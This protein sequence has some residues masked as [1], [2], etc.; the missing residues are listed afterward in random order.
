MRRD[1]VTATKVLA[2]RFRGRG[3]WRIQ[4]IF[5]ALKEASNPTRVELKIDLFFVKKPIDQE[6]AIFD[7]R[8]EQIG[9]MQREPEQFPNPWSCQ[10]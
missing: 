4:K 8:L 6:R 9:K 3:E 10:D 5:S 2:N 1:N 7:C